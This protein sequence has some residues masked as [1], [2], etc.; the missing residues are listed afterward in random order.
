MEGRFSVI[1]YIYLNISN[2]DIKKTK[3]QAIELLLMLNLPNNT[4]KNLTFLVLDG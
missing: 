1:L 3:N 2:T 4:F